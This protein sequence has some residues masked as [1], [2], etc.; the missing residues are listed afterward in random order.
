MGE[1]RQLRSSTTAI[2]RM[3]RQTAANCPKTARQQ[4]HLR[5]FK[6]TAIRLALNYY[7][8]MGPVHNDIVVYSMSCFKTIEGEYTKSPFIYH[9]MNLLRLLGDEGTHVRFCWIS[10]HSGIGGNERVEQRAKE[11][12]KETLD[13]D[14]D[15]LA[16]IHYTDIKSLVNSYIPKLVQTK[17]D[18]AVH[19]IY[20]D[21]VKLI[22]RPPKEFQHLTRGGEAVITWLGI[23]HTKS[24][25]SHIFP[26]EHRLFVII[27]VIHWPLTICYWNVHC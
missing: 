20:L 13:Q 8:N 12:P 22:M 16:S 1:W 6:A 24:T 25:K 11:T 14:I 27:V 18:V 3:V 17:W 7:Q 4:H 2:S 23:D 10:S 5:S 9:I 15:P 19:G 21:L 26:Q